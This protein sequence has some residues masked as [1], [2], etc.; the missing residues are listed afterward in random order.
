MT[1]PA[2]M[3]AIG[4]NAPGGP[5]ALVAIERPLPNVGPEEILVRVRAAGVNRPD[6]MQRAGKYPPPPGA[7]DI[8]GLE[9]AGEVVARGHKAS[10]FAIGDTVTCLV[11]GG[12]YAEYCAV[13]ESNALRAP[14]SFPMVEAAAIP[15][16]FFT[17]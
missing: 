6:A 15:E 10:R 12:G 7:S 17:V 9:F 2:T 5:E 13:H 11:A 8:L 16:T 1:L 3:T 4:V 14:A